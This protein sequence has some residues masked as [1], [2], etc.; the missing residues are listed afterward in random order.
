MSIFRQFQSLGDELLTLRSVAWPEFFRGEIFRRPV[1]PIQNKEKKMSKAD[2]K[3]RQK[4]DSC[5]LTPPSLIDVRAVLENGLKH[6]YQHAKV[7]F[8]TNFE[9]YEKI[10]LI[11]QK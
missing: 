2:A 4:I 1:N 10:E 11:S 5:P 9:N 7:D 8:S 3:R 6:N